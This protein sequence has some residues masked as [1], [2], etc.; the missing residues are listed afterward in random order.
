MRTHRTPVARR[1]SSPRHGHRV[2][3][4]SVVLVTSLGG[5][6]ACG[7]DAGPGDEV[8]TEDLVEI[9][10]DL[11]DLQDR[12]G[13]LRGGP[14]DA[15]AEPATDIAD[16]DGAVEGL[17]GEDSELREG[18][19]VTVGAVVTEVV[20][21]NDDGIA[22]VVAAGDDAEPVPVVWTGTPL[23]LEPGA[24]VEVAGTVV[25]VQRDTFEEDFGVPVEGWLTDP[26]SF[27]DTHDA[28][29]ALAADSVAVV[30]P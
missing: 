11:A 24:V 10:D 6:A 22:F 26:G 1:T 14:F 29:I 12:V 27:F 7:E 8:S 21:C 18:Q 16:A 5:L 25:V 2:A 30:A 20:P 9:E 15:A 4:A 28:E 19:Q 17:L 23:D 13:L 3:A